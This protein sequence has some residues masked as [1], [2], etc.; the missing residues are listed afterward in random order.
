VVIKDIVVIFL[1]GEIDRD[2][3][4]DGTGCDTL[5]D[6]GTEVPAVACN[7]DATG[8]NLTLE[9]LVVNLGGTQGIS[10]FFLSSSVAND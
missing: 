5:R 1:L 7:D 9:S 2:T 6:A 3:D 10:C 4:E 8:T